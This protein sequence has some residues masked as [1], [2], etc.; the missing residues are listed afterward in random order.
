MPSSSDQTFKRLTTHPVSTLI[1]RLAVPCM[2]SMM[3]TSIYNMADTFFVGQL[4]N[5]AASGAVGVVFSLMV[6]I[7]A[8]GLFFGQG[9]GNYISRQLGKQDRESA[10][11]MAST[12]L[13][14]ALICGVTLT[15][16][17]LIWGEGLAYF[18]GA[19]DTI[20]PFAISYQR[21]ILLAAPFLIGSYVL[22]NQL[23]YQG[24]AALS[25]VGMA[26]GSVLN[27]V[28]DPIFIFALD[29]GI[30]GAALATCLSQMVSFCILLCMANHPQLI[31]LS[32]GNIRPS[33]HIFT[34]I[35]G[36]GVPSL[37]RQGLAAVATI[38][39]NHA[40]GN[41]GDAAI[42]AISVVTRIIQFGYSAMI[43]FGQG[44][45][46]VCGYCFG[47]GL[48]SRVREGFFFCVRSSFLFLVALGALGLYF[49]PQLVAVFRDDPDV[50]AYGT[51][52]LRCQCV[53]FISCCWIVPSNMMLQTIGRTWPATI[54]AAA[55]QGFVL[56]PC[57]WILSAT[58]GL[59]GILIAQSV[60]DLLTLA[61]AIPLQWKVLEE[62]R[63]KGE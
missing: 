1:P 19:T 4:G 10:A 5:N 53:S 18:L 11:I 21:Y 33:L 15:V 29:M 50:I 17:G 39:L 63:V 43:G 3:V 2:I 8:L 46:P 59:T 49:A 28:L 20:A 51:I 23:R 34:S 52:A 44:F 14:F 37:G 41:Y 26:S 40:A 31:K 57:I 55:R 47:A 35:C 56:M 36:G 42:A 25:M 58:F 13:F 61:I 62:L 45:Q 38:L 60:A 22:N 16:I 54:V 6:M 27:I 9:T 12:G 24:K 48:Y 7:L 30:A 32:F